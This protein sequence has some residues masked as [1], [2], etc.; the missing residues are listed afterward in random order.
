MMEKRKYIAIYFSKLVKL[1][2]DGERKEDMMGVKRIPLWKENSKIKDFPQLKNNE[3][4][5]VVVVG[6][7][8][9]GVTTA[10]LLATN[11]VKVILVDREEIGHGT[12]GHTTAKITAQHGMIYNEFISHF[13]KE[14]ALLYFQSQVDAMTRMEKIIKD[15]A[16]ECHF[17]KQDAYLFTNDEKNQRKLESEFEAYQTLDI[18]GEG[19][20]ELPINFPMKYALKM[21]DQAQFHPMY[22]LKALVDEIIKHG[23]K[24][25]E[26]TPIYDID[27]TDHRVVRALNQNTIV[28][29]HVVIATHFPFYEG[30]ALYS[31]R[32]YPSRSYVAGF[33]SD[34]KYPGGMYLSVDNPTRSLRSIIHNEQEIWLLGGEDHKTGQYQN[35][36]MPYSLLKDFGEANFSVKEW[37]YEW[38][39]Q[40]YITL[41]KLPYIGRLNKNRP[42]IFVATGYRKWGMTNSMVAAN[43]I[44]GLILQKDN[45]YIDLYR[46]NRFH[47]DPDLKQFI[48]TNTNV[49]KEFVTGK[50]VSE[51]QD[52]K[53]LKTNSATKVKH[54]GQTIGLFKDMQGKVHAVDTTCTHLGCEVNW[55]NTEKTWDCPCHGSRFEYNGDVVEGPAIEP[56]NKIDFSN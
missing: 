3:K 5:D 4:T 43:I 38:S 37:Q 56:L 28:C 54:H 27:S 26:K 21:R 16:I 47:A 14:Q 49:A 1:S 51:K 24:I 29:D 46:S 48:S 34:V 31:A 40:D 42:E 32:M 20:L 35:N 15:L 8:L 9:T 23:G 18:D 55:N 44:S 39:A 10:Y 17:E 19:L 41:D 6:A 33:S 2:I 22:Y 7:G 52:M 53:Q 12:T 50:I 13:G 25:Y 30:E 11:G 36:T 45:P